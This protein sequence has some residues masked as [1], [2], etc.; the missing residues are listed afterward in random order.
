ME[1]ILSFYSTFIQASHI[2]SI[3]TLNL[4]LF[5]NMVAIFGNNQL[6]KKIQKI[7]PIIKKNNNFQFGTN[8]YIRNITYVLE[9]ELLHTFLQKLAFQQCTPDTLLHNFAFTVHMLVKLLAYS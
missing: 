6:C 7:Y 5:F 4:S 2:L 8:F 1:N 9:I 3:C